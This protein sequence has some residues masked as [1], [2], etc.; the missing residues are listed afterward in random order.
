MLRQFANKQ[1]QN[2]DI[3]EFVEGYEHY[4]W[5]ED[6]PTSYT[7]SFE[8]GWLAAETLYHTFG[9]LPI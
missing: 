4:R 7:V 2:L 9:F 3:F 8:A 5:G 6:M 1:N